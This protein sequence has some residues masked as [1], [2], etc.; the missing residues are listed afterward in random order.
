MKLD[1][2]NIFSDLERWRKAYLS[3][4][5]SQSYSK[6]T[7]EVYKYSIIVFCEY[8]LEE[9]QENTIKDINAIVISGYFNF[10]EDLARKRGANVNIEGNYLLST[11]KEAYIRG[12]R[13]FFRFI[14]NN[15]NEQYDFI[16][17]FKDIKIGK[18]SEAKREYLTDDESHRLIQYLEK[19]KSE[20]QNFLNYRN[21]LLIKIMLFGGLRISEALGVKPKDFKKLEDEEVYEVKIFGKGGYRQN[22]H[23]NADI[24]EEEMNFIQSARKRDEYIMVSGKGKQLNRSNVYKMVNT[25]YQKC[26]ID[27]RG[28][29]TLRHSV[30]M[31]FMRSGVPITTTQ[32]FLRQKSITSTQI[33]VK[34]ETEDVIRALKETTRS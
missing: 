8:I 1:T 32:K 18:E 19:K 11:T 2:G 5:R 21:A 22:T 10:L 4:I 33:Y 23:I 9:H 25:I 30:A 3:H 24:I 7:I 14:S 12:V 26:L 27:K 34:A 15:N 16:K 17:Y 20:K 29:H 28:L 13:S 31:K 6:N